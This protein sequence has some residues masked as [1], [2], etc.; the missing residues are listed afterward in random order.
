MNAGM[1]FYKFIGASHVTKMYVLDREAKQIFIAVL[2]RF[3]KIIF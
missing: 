1:S 3:L 2:L